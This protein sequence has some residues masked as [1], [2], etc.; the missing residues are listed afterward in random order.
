[1]HYESTEQMYAH[2]FDIIS[3]RP[4]HWRWWRRSGVQVRKYITELRLCMKYWRSM[5]DSFHCRYSFKLQCQ[6]ISHKPRSVF[7]LT[8]WIRKDGRIAVAAWFPGFQGERVYMDPGTRLLKVQWR[9]SGVSCD[10]S[11]CTARAVVNVI[12]VGRWYWTPQHQYRCWSLC[13]RVARRRGWWRFT[14]MD[15]KFIIRELAQ[16]NMTM[17]HQ[18]GLMNNRPI[19]IDIL[20]KTIDCDIQDGI[21]FRASDSFAIYRTLK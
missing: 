16:D 5:K 15:F 7:T 2:M 11:R 10:V 9:W 21:H 8:C 3:R 12:R 1:M 18:Y 19:A 13:R 17:R 6:Y 20:F 4:H 14:R